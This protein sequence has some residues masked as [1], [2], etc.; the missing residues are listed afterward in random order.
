VRRSSTR[1]VSSRFLIRS[2][3]SVPSSSHNSVRGIFTTMRCSGLNVPCLSLCIIR[4]KTTTVLAV[5]GVRCVR[6]EHCL[7]LGVVLSLFSLSTYSQLTRT[8]DEQSLRHLQEVIRGLPVDSSLRRSLEAL[9]VTHDAQR[10]LDEIKGFTPNPTLQNALEDAVLPD[11]IHKPWMDDMKRSGI[12]LAMFE[13]H[14]VWRADSHFQP[15]TARR[16]LY[17]RRYDGAGSQVH[18]L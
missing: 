10:R 3:T 5:R 9:Y 13:V 18:K 1:S 7:H 4:S 14:G 2:P 17:R 15:Q 11:G 12:K 16:I 6:S 8:P